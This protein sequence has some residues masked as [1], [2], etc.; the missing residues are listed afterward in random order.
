MRSRWAII[1]LSLGHAL[2]CGNPHPT[3]TA[4]APIQA[5]SDKDVRLTLLGDNF[6]PATI[7]DPASG[8]RIATSDGFR[9]HAG[10]ADQWIELTALD[11]L[12]TGTLAVTLSSTTAQRLPPG[13]LDVRVADPRGQVAT[14][15]DAFLE[16]GADIDPPGLA[17]TSPSPDT[18][19]APGLV[20]RG[21]FHASDPPPGAI[22]S[23]GW[24]AYENGLLRAGT[25]CFVTPGIAAT[26]CG[27]EFTI[28]QTRHEGDTLRIVADA[29]DASANGNRAEA[30]LA[31]TL[32][33]RPGLRSISPESGGT[34]GGTD[35]VILGS[36]FLAGSGVTIDGQL[37][38]PEGGIVVDEYTISG[39]MP[40]HREGAVD[41]FVHTPLGDTPGA[42]SFTYLPPPAIALIAPDTGAPAG[43]TAVSITGVNFSADTRIYFGLTLDLSVPL[44]DQFVQSNSSII[45]RAPAGTGQ[46]TVWAFD[47]ALGFTKLQGGFTWSSP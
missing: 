44:A 42:L 34:G 9:A 2:G 18:L 39:R 23:L 12:S 35:V 6:V 15:V 33:G 26:D 8:H 41:F 7:L 28:S 24:N 32:R 22:A 3:L 10:K 46:T 16:L 1:P 37:L 21:S 29:T 47:D 36:G 40:A 13:P 25:R 30:S 45:G 19:F 17:F 31:F 14:L 5:Y 27:F 20:V 11:W 4:V 43:G 38:F